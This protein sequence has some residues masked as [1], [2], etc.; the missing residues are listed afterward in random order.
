MKVGIVAYDGCTPSMIVG[1][2][3]ILAFANDHYQ[4]REKNDLFDVSIITETG[5]P[6]NGF[7][8]F[9]IQAQR[10]IKTK[11]EFD[12]IYIPGN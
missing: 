1:V 9:P 8:K 5:Q 2:M 7:S 11:S 10:S 3:D 12:L 4:S 6:A